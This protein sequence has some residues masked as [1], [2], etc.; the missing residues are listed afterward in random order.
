VVSRKISSYYKSWFDA[1]M[2]G[3][4]QSSPLI[5]NEKCSIITW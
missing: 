1:H 4:K 5:M 3:K 2:F